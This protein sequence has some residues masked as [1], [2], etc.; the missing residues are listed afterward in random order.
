VKTILINILAVS[1]FFL[2]TIIVS[3]SEKQHFES[4][5]AEINELFEK[6]LTTRNDFSKEQINN[7]IIS[8]IEE[9]LKNEKSFKYDFS[10]I[11]HIVVLDSDDKNL[12]IYN[13]NLALFDGTH[14]YFGFIQYQHSKN[15]MKVFKLTD[16]SEFHGEQ[17]RNFKSHIEW[18]GAL[19]YEIIEKK[20]NRNTY[21]T[22][23]GWDGG[24]FMINRKVIEILTFS[25][26]GLPEFGR[27]MF[28]V[29]NSRIDR[30]IYEYSNRA[31]MLLR[32]NRKHDIIVADHL[33][34]AEQKYAGMSQYYGPDMSYDAYRFKGGRW[35]LEEDI[36]PN[37]AINFKKDN[38]INTIKRQ[39]ENR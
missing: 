32:Y 13:W 27:K 16:L 29:N 11:N 5:I 28:V 39:Q 21:Y 9:I 36:D 25:R 17:G 2:S 34:P 14:K 10:N 7:Q 8:I 6:I 12:R 30:M 24:D 37:L 22:L 33:S 31:T 1:C 23:I 19:Y 26:R 3:A 4:E 35:I 20:W 15:D 38:K 18:Y